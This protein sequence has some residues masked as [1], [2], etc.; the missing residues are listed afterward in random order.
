MSDIFALQLM[1]VPQVTEEAA[2]AVTSLYPT[3]LSLAKAYTMLVSPL[4]IG[5]DV[6][7]DGDKRA[8]EKMLKNKSDMVN[9]G[10]SKNI[11]KLIW[12]EG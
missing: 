4:L 9:A 6:T 11:F 8:Q 10:A 12:A 7:S 5:T 3:L 1:Q 2:L